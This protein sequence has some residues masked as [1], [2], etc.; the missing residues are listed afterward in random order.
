MLQVYLILET[1]PSARSTRAIYRCLLRDARKLQQTPHFFIRRDL[2]LEQ[3]GH[4]R[5]VDSLPL[6]DGQT[7]RVIGSEV[8]S[9]LEDFRKLRDNAFQMGS[10]RLDPIKIIQLSFRQN[11]KLSDRKTLNAKLDD[12]ILY[13]TI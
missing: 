5:F 11:V 7:K 2:Q 13:V 8:L 3:W 10:P 4:G 6:S 9:S 12:A 1:M